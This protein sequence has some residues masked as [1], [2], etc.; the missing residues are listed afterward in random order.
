MSMAVSAKTEEDK[1]LEEA[2]KL[3]QMEYEKQHAKKEESP[4]KS[5]LGPLPPLVLSTHREPRP[6]KEYKEEESKL[7]EEISDLRKKEEARQAKAKE[8]QEGNEER[9]KRLQEQR[10]LI[11]K[12]KQEQRKEELH[13]FVKSEPK[14]HFPLLSLR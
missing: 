6:V 9:K 1:Q 7:K 13:E 4:K 14:V 8:D 5:P 12:Q 10:E 2:I 11:R 3:S